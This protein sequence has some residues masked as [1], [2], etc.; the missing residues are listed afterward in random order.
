MGE[1]KHD[2]LLAILA[3]AVN[4]V[5]SKDSEN[6]RFIPTESNSKDKPVTSPSSDNNPMEQ[7]P[8]SPPR[9]V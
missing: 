2:E 5:F 3:S 7:Y 4:L 1:Y 6:N 9:Q 8:Y